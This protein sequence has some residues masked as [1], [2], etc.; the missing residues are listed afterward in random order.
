MC[1]SLAALET[2]QRQVYEGALKSLEDGSELTPAQREAL[3]ILAG[4]TFRR[5]EA[6]R[7]EF[8]DHRRSHTEGSSAGRPGNA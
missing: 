2:S 4:K 1:I 5:L 3:Q 8:N 6:T 7:L